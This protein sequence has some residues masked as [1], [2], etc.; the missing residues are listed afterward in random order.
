MNSCL[1]THLFLSC[2]GGKINC[3]LFK[4][5]PYYVVTMI[6]GHDVFQIRIVKTITINSFILT[7]DTSFA[8]KWSLPHQCR[9]FVCPERKIWDPKTMNDWCQILL[10]HIISEMGQN[11]SKSTRPRPIYRQGWY[12]VPGPHPLQSWAFFVLGIFFL[13]PVCPTPSVSKRTPCKD[14]QLNST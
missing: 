6:N 3:C 11:P 10:S 5:Q 9:P 2:F 13:Q 4:K 7:D 8:S 12:L 14:Q 1:K